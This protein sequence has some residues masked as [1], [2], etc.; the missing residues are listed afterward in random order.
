MRPVLLYHFCS[1]ASC[2][3]ES[4]CGRRLEQY[5]DAQGWRTSTP[6]SLSRSLTL[7]PVNAAQQAGTDV[8]FGTDLALIFSV[9]VILSMFKMLH[10][11]FLLFLLKHRSQD[12]LTPH[13]KSLATTKL[14]KSKAASGSVPSC[15]AALLWPPE[16]F[17]CW[18]WNCFFV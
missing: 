11:A 7:T 13:G 9:V 2:W 3:L 4:L 16:L 15:L 17:D 14:W 12:P 10:F 18:L 6:T 5:P 1:V 8:S